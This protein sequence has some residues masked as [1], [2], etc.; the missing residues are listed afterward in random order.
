MYDDPGPFDSYPSRVSFLSNRVSLSLLCSQNG[1]LVTDV[2]VFA[3]FAWKVYHV[4]AAATS[5]HGVV[6]LRHLLLF[7]FECSM[8]T[9]D[10][11]L[12]TRSSVYEQIASANKQTHRS[13][14]NSRKSHFSY[15]IT[16]A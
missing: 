16:R 12:T 4:K 15:L 10:S 8:H 6:L 3:S 11:L 7:P 1:L 5:L 14:L 2:K 13:P 9:C